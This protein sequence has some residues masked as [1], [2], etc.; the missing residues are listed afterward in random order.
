MAR[1]A[2]AS[3]GTFSFGPALL[4]IT[5]AG[6]AVRTVGLF[7]DLWLDEIWSINLVADLTSPLQ[8]LTNLKHDNN[9]PLNSLFL[10]VLRGTAA[11]WHYRLLAWVTGVATVLM[12]GVL[13]RHLFQRLH[14]FSTTVAAHTAGLMT[15]FVVAV[16]YSA[17]P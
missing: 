6:A 10:F 3:T 13:G 16:S 9:H 17:D 11:D 1:P 2:G 5:A 12:A 8:I 15:A 14:K 7:H 4:A